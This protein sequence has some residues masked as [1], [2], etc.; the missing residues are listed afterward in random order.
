MV[1]SIDLACSGLYGVE[2]CELQNA[3]DLRGARSVSGFDLT[4]SFSGSFS[5]EVPRGIGDPVNRLNTA[6]SH[7]ADAWRLNA[8]VGVHS[9][10]PHHV[11]YHRALANTANTLVRANL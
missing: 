6:L 5:Y 7:R 11:V 4:H 3:Y 9:A 2:G 8:L 1:K 10:T